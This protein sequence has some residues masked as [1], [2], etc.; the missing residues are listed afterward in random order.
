MPTDAAS[1]IRNHSSSTRFQLRP[2]A[3]MLDNG[4]ETSVPQFIKA[5]DMIRLDMHSLK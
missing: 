2:W 1:C 5:G 4:V 3:S